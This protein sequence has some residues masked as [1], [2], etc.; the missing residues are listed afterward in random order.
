MREKTIVNQFRLNQVRLVYLLCGDP[1]IY[2][3]WI[4]S[5]CNAGLSELSL[6]DL[7]CCCSFWSRVIVMWIDWLKMTASLHLS[8]C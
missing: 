5:L 1:F 3:F 4:A 6:E 2:G 8:R 7:S